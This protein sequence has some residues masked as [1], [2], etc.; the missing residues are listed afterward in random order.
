MAAWVVRGGREGESQLE[1]EALEKGVLAIRFSNMTVDLTGRT[2][3]QIDC[4]YKQLHPGEGPRR[5]SQRIAQIC[6]FIHAMA[7]GDLIVMPRRGQ[8]IMAVG[9]VSGEYEYLP[10]SLLGFVHRRTVTWIDKEAPRSAVSEECRKSLN[11][12][13][14]VFDISHYGHEIY[15]LI[16]GSGSPG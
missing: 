4:L 5:T 12:P 11:R 8:Q 10:D 7:I 13:P 16:R 15:G 1:E 2:R 3:Q 9:E 6:H 14:T